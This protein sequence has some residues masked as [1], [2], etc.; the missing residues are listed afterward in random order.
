M[1][2]CCNCSLLSDKLLQ[3]QARMMKQARFTCSLLTQV[4]ATL[5]GVVLVDRIGRRAVLTQASVQVCSATLRCA[6][7][8]CAALCCLL[9]SDVLLC[10]ALL[11]CAV[12]CCAVLCCAVLCCC[13]LRDP[14]RVD[15][16][17]HSGLSVIMKEISRGKSLLYNVY[18]YSLGLDYTGQQ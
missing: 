16:S 10:C 13:C 1:H 4:V 18:M 9:L 6:V 2:A 14:R 5:V 17:V 8:C 3:A 15:F 12:L 11:C 7:L